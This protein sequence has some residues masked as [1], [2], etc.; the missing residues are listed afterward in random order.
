MITEGDLR[1]VFEY[2][3]KNFSSYEGY[4]NCIHQPEPLRMCEWGEK[5]DHIELICSRWE[6]RKEARHG[7]N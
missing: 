2:M 4:R 1:K 3:N 5:R 6:K 7:A